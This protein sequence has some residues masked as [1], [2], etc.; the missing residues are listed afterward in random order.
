M[1]K[2]LVRGGVVF[3]VLLVILMFATL[4]PAANAVGVAAGPPEGF[5]VVLEVGA[6]PAEVARAHGLGVTQVYTHVLNGFAAPVPAQAL[7]GLRNDPRVR[8]VAPDVAY[9]IEVQETPTGIDR[10]ERD[11]NGDPI[12]G[13]TEPINYDVAIIDT[14]IYAGHSDLN[15]V[16]GRNFTGGNVNAWGDKNGHGTHTAGTVGAKDNTIGVV[17]VVP[18]VRLW[19]LRVCTSLCPTSAMIAAMDWI[20]ARKTSTGTDKIDFAVANM[21]IS[22]GV[23]DNNCGNT[24]NDPLHTAVCRLVSA[25][26]PLALAA[27]NDASSK[28]NYKEAITVS[29]LADFNG[30]GGGGAAATCRTDT[31]DTRANF[32]N[33]GPNVDIMAPGTCIK[34]TWRDGGYRTIS[35][36]SMAAP[37]VAGAVVYYLYRNGLPPATD[38]VGANAI[39]DAIV[40]AG[41]ATTHACGYANDSG[42]QSTEPLLFLNALAFG[43]NST[44]QTT[45]GTVSVP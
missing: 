21:S 33:W 17:G 2:R 27:G 7:A 25:G 34:S 19:A 15:V 22:S 13:V 14:G 4:A 29:A 10:A 43:G 18:G 31:D 3:S 32:S 37:H 44:C 12:D 45:T 9:P 23:E 38:A 6:N 26:V 20:V 41:I 24:N 5:I 35:G 42:T 28:N 30:K 8:F 16:G 11:L 36:T 1:E 40:N 39:R